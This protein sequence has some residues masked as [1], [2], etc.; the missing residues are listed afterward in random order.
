MLDIP[1]QSVHHLRRST[2]EIFLAV[3]CPLLLKVQACEV[4]STECGRPYFKLKILDRWYASKD[5]RKQ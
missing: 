5:R 1:K 3:S 4:K 2:E